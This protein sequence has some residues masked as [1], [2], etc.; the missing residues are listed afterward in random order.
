MLL[1]DHCF[2]FQVKLQGP[3]EWYFGRIFAKKFLWRLAL[4]NCYVRVCE[5]AFN[6]L[7]SLNRTY[8]RQ[9]FYQLYFVPTT[10]NCMYEE[11][12]NTNAAPF[13]HRLTS[14]YTYT[15][16]SYLTGDTL[17]LRQEIWQLD[18]RGCLSIQTRHQSTDPHSHACEHRVGL[19][20]AE[21]TCSNFPM[22]C[23]VVDSSCW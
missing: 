17:R 22:Y 14:N 4:L 21:S 18:W 6:V 1:Y 7:V 5:T 11:S 8:S 19:G 12:H 3:K 2:K 15:F 23:R 10:H 16:S 13:K 9:I 20:S